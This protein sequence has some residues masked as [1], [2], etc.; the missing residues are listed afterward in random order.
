MIYGDSGNRGVHHVFNAMPW[1]CRYADDG[2]L[3]ADFEQKPF[4]VY[5]AALLVALMQLTGGVATVLPLNETETVVFFIGVMAGA[6][7]FA[8]IQGVRLLPWS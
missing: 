8:A 4:H 1:T 2:Y 7:I 6:I 3:S 5:S